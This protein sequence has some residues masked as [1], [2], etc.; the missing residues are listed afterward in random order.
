MKY[1]QQKEKQKHVNTRE[2][3]VEKKLKPYLEQISRESSNRTKS[4]TQS[5]F[6]FPPV[7]LRDP[8][9]LRNN[10]V[11]FDDKMDIVSEV[12]PNGNEFE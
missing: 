3:F 10:L 2:D 8:N 9:S 6:G 11:I 5:M 4:M 7:D 1:G 12:F